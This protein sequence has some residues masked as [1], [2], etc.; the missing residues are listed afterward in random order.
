MRAGRVG[1][2]DCR[3]VPG[4]AAREPSPDQ[5]EIPPR[6]LLVGRDHQQLA[7]AE[8]GGAGA[9]AACLAPLGAQIA[10]GEETPAEAAPPRSRC[11]VR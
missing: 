4:L 6:V 7:Q 3:R 5:L 11:G 10:D 8:R 9:E 1:G 2:G